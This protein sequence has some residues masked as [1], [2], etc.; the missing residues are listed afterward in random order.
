MYP[1]RGTRSNYC[2]RKPKSSIALVWHFPYPDGQSGKRANG[3]HSAMLTSRLAWQS[4][5]DHRATTD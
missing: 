2:V 1:E 3:R 5:T 4:T